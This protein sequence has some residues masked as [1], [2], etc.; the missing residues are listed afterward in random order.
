MKLKRNR[1]IS[2]QTIPTTHTP[3]TVIYCR[4]REREKRERQ[5]KCGQIPA[6]S[7]FMIYNIFEKLKNWEIPIYRHNSKPF[8]D[9]NK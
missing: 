6:P 5:N 2:R 3:H 7:I 1:I 9:R 8:F 4:E